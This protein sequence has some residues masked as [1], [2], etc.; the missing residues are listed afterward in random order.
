MDPGADACDPPLEQ[1]IGLGDRLRAG[2]WAALHELTG[3]YG[4][5]P[6]PTSMR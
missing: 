6:V 3:R 1:L 4:S 5:A 2:G